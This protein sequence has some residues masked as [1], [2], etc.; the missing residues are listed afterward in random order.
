[1]ST[2][3]VQVDPKPGIIDVVEDETVMGAAERLGYQW[4]T[5]CG[6]NGECRVCVMEVVAGASGLS[7][8]DELEETAIQST[9]GSLRR[10]GRQLRQA[11]RA[12]V[13]G[14]GVTVFKRG[15]RRPP[16]D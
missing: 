10:R 4:P 6:G 14:D 9:F 7:V 13:V 11:C 16:T 8:P 5:L 15:V 3:K 1:V 2:F 12:R